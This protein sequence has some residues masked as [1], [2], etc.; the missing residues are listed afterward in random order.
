MRRDSIFYTF[1]QRSSTLI[2]DLLPN[3][4]ANAAAYRFDSVSVKEAQFE[5][6]GVFLPPDGSPDTVYFC[7][8]QMQK[9]KNLYERIF[10]QIFL[11]F[12]RHR[13]RF[14]DWQIIVI[15]P[16]RSTEQDRLHP[17]RV[18]LNSEQM[19]RIYLDELG[20]IR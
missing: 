10:A 12:Y 8:V 14:T 16:S 9:I 3:P 20:D 2:L 13:D 15:Y 7:E 17:F 11:Y 4:P 5:M 19:H 1:F 6:D 18:M